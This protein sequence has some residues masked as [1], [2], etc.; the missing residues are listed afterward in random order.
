MNLLADKFLSWDSELK[1]QA[2][3]TKSEILGFEVRNS[4]LTL[5]SDLRLPHVGWLRYLNHLNN[6]LNNHPNNCHLIR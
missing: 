5:A 1:F 2:R 6:H 3:N 4:N